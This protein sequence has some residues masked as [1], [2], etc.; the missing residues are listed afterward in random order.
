MVKGGDCCP[1]WMN[2]LILIVGILYLLTDLGTIAWWSVSWW[3]IAFLAC[4]LVG[5]MKGK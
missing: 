1:S 4:G 3:T 5:V 2:W